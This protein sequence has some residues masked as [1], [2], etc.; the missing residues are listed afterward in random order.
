MRFLLTNIF[1]SR[2]GPWM[3]PT[4]AL[5]LGAAGAT[6]ALGVVTTQRGVPARKG[7]ALVL[8]ASLAAGLLCAAERDYDSFRGWDGGRYLDA[9]WAVQRIKEWRAMP[10]GERWSDRLVRGGLGLAAAAAAGAAAYGGTRWY[11]KRA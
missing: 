5:A 6:V 9:P 8:G 7:W 2:T 10:A 11:L 4:L 3:D 1:A